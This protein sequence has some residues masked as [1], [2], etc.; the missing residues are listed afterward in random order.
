MN[1]IGTKWRWT[2]VERP[3]TES[4]ETDMIVCHFGRTR[5][6][7][8]T[9]WPFSADHQRPKINTV[10]F[11]HSTDFMM[12]CMLKVNKHKLHRISGVGNGIYQFLQLPLY[13]HDTPLPLTSPVGLWFGFLFSRFQLTIFPVRTSK[14]F[15]FGIIGISSAILL[16]IPP[17]RQLRKPYRAVDSRSPGLTGSGTVD[18]KRGCLYSDCN[19]NT[20]FLLPLVLQFCFVFIAD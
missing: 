20:P 5:L 10:H 4:S 9:L 19:V 1:H 2:P 16:P 12:Q 18:L 7:A 14:M 17:K 11:K 8:Q 6:T 3:G 13:L 15:T